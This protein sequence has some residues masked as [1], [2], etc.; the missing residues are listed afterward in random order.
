MPHY[1]NRKNQ[2]NYI[3]HT[4]SARKK[5]ICQFCALKEN[6]D[7]TVRFYEHFKVIRN[8]FGYDKWDGRTVKDHLMVV[9]KEHT[10]SLATL[11]KEAAV[12]YVKIVSTYESDGYD[13]YARSPHSTIKSVPHQ[14]THFIK[15]V[16]KT[17]RG[18]IHLESPYISI[19]F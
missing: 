19:S 7:E 10:E 9:P 17:H 4:K 15:T 18:V 3:A 13:V 5:G 14:H 6:S 12:E 8:I 11:S 1:R 16:G 2:T